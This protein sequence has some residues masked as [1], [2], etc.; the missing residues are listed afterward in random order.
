MLGK[1]EHEGLYAIC[2]RVNCCVSP[3]CICC[4]NPQYL[5]ME[6]HL[7]MRLYKSLVKVGSYWSRA[8]P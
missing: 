1:R 8:G 7:A 4:P 3:K 2:S 5:R 6:S